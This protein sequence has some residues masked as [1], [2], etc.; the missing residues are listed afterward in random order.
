[1]S[2]PT[3]NMWYETGIEHDAAEHMELLQAPLQHVALM[4]MLPPCAGPS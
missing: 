2:E 1:M 4:V 3:G